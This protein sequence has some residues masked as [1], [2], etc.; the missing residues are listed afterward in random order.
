[1]VQ[2]T[3]QVNIWMFVRCFSKMRHSMQKHKNRFSV[4]RIFLR[5]NKQDKQTNRCGTNRIVNMRQTLMSLIN[6][7]YTYATMAAC[8]C[9]WHQM[10]K[11]KRNVVRRIR[12]RCGWWAS[13]SWWKW[14]TKYFEWNLI[15]V[16]TVPYLTCT[17]HTESDGMSPR[18]HIVMRSNKQTNLFPF[19]LSMLV[20]NC[21][22][23]EKKWTT[24]SMQLKL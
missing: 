6:N 23:K 18:E 8:E 2:K 12:A 5:A 20:W 17:L 4:A 1:M 13:D 7:K 16:S 19:F 9:K 10:R 15:Y 21:F 22:S 3:N 14:T 11:C 24:T